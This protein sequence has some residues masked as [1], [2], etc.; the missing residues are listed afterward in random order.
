MPDA[1]AWLIT[2]YRD[3]QHVLRHPEVWS[4]DLLGKAGFSMFQHEEAR[5]VLEAD[6]WARDTRLQSDLPIHREYYAS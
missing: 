6:G 4:N 1:E 2:R 3:V 5:A